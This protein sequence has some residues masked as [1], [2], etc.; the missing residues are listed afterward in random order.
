MGLFDEVKRTAGRVSKG[1]IRDLTR[2][3]QKEIE[4]RLT[5]TGSGRRSTSSTRTTQKKKTRDTKT[6]SAGADRRRGGSGASL[7]GPN[8]PAVEYDV[9]ARGLPKFDY[10][11]ER[12]GAPDPGE[13]VW[14][15][16]PYEENDG[17]GK[18]RPVLVLADTDEHVVFAQLT[19]KDHD[20]ARERQAKY[21][22]Y[23]MDI[24]TGNWDEQ[25]RPSEVRLDRLLVTHMD[26]VRR[27]GGQL[28]RAFYEDVVR[29]LRELHNS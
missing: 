27:E 23:W 29:A 4:N 14:T 28:D 12:D 11:P 15:W 17:R 26:Q 18:D 9:A 24:G 22:V 8:D 5:G 7:P 21:G 25:R 16:V 1:L 3:A 6:K 2:T 20:D 13:V 10:R 19:S